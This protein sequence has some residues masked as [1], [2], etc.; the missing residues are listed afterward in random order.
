[1]QFVHRLSTF[2]ALLLLVACSGGPATPT[3]L[4]FDAVRPIQP[5]PA[6]ANSTQFRL[7]TPEFNKA[8]ATNREP[9]TS[10]QLV[11]APQTTPQQSMLV[12]T[13]PP[14]A[15]GIAR[16][17]AALLDQPGGGI[18]L[19]LPAGEIVTVTGKSADGHYL[20]AYTNEGIVGWVAAAE[21]T[22]YG[23]DDLVVVDNTA[24]PGPIATLVA[25]AMQPVRVL[26]TL[27]A[28]PMSVTSDE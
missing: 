21:L 26:E 24:G 18:L 13:Q 12:T 16:G 7:A 11:E 9:F 25:E 15:L 20:A 6:Y 17:G 4:P 3:A 10:T 27:V 22:L 28:T 5:T 8:L 23:A 2:T 19:Q 14:S 1:M